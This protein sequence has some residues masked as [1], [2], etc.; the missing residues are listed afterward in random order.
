MKKIILAA[1]ISFTAAWILLGLLEK[2][3]DADMPD[4]MMEQIN[5]EN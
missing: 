2:M 3:L 5:R 4:W 1:A